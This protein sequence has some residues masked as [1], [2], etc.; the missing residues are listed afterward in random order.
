MRQLSLMLTIIQRE[1]SEQFL[2][3]YEKK[4]LKVQL[5]LFAQGTARGEML[6]LLGLRSASRTVLLSFVTAEMWRALC[7]GLWLE[8]GIGLPG[9]GIAF[10]VPVSSLA[11]R[12]CLAFLTQNQRVGLEEESSLKGTEQELIIAMTNLGYSELV[13][14]AARAAGANGGTILHAKGTGMREA[15][16]FLGISLA[17]EKEVI[18][19]VAK[20]AVRSRLMQAV[21]E[22]AGLR[23]KAGTILFSLPVTAAA[24]LFEKAEDAC[25]QQ[26]PV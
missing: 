10:L 16:K 19:I 5:A 12:Q 11:G 14:K 9:S 21:S 22:Q 4:G 26:P 1:R 2:E 18:L 24:G 15:E 17:A 7:R 13:M 6:D 8:Q 20:T 23:S 3:F 25:E